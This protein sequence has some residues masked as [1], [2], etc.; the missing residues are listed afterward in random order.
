MVSAWRHSAVAKS[1]ELAPDLTSSQPIPG[2]DFVRSNDRITCNWGRY[3][4]VF[5]DGDR[6][7]L[8]S[9]PLC[10]SERCPRGHTGERD[11]L[12]SHQPAGSDGILRFS[13]AINTS[14][15]GCKVGPVI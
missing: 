11:V 4:R 2:S 15:T 6:A 7:V 13:L 9:Y 12:N 3:Y 1:S 8:H 14:L 5:P 10:G